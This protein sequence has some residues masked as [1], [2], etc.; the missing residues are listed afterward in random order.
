MLLYFAV[1]S[2][3]SFYFLSIFTIML[4]FCYTQH[5]YSQHTNSLSRHHWIKGVPLLICGACICFC[6]RWSNSS[7][8]LFDGRVLERNL[9]V[10]TRTPLLNAFYVRSEN[11]QQHPFFFFNIGHFPLF[12]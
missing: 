1:F 12:P 7:I 4:D 3:F 2:L 8:C 10:Y 11:L 5:T 6:L 9:P